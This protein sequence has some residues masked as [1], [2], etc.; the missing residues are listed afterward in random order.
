MWGFPQVIGAID[1]SHIPI[2]KPTESPSDYFCRKGFYSIILQGVVDSRGLFID[3][4]IGWP[5]KV[6]DAQVFT[7]PTFYSKHNTGTLL[8]NWK[9]TLDGT[10]IPLLVLETPAYPWLMKSYSDS[11][12]LSRAQQHYN[13]WQ[14][15]ARMVVENDFGRLKG[16]WKCLLKCMD[17]YNIDVPQM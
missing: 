8:P 4:N 3:V 17:Y 11:G 1:G 16:R 10:D 6:H 5:G 15:R 7:N 2:L 9:K 14:S 13:Y 12:N